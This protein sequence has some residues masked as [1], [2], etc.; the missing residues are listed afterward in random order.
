MLSCKLC[1]LNK[2][3]VAQTV[4]LPELPDF[5]Q[6]FLSHAMLGFEAKDGQQI[7]VRKAMPSL[8]LRERRQI[9]LSEPMF[10]AKL[11]HIR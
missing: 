2:V 3:R 6:V 4:R 8:D 10:V 5:Q 11:R 1:N 9:L 7:P